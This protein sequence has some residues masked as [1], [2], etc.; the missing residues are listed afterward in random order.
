MTA[1]YVKNGAPPPNVQTAWGW[2]LPAELPVGG[3]EPYAFAFDIDATAAEVLFNRPL[4]TLGDRMPATLFSSAVAPVP[5][6][7]AA[8]VLDRVVILR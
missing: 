2:M 3:A 1:T 4:S 6:P 8:L 7:A 5:L